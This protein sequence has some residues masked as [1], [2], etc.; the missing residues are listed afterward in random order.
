MRNSGVNNI[1]KIIGLIKK[2]I[3]IPVTKGFKKIAID[4]LVYCEGANSQTSF[5]FSDKAT[6]IVINRSLKELT[7][8]LEAKGFVRIHK[9]YFINLDMFVSFTNGKDGTVY[10]SGNKSLTVSRTYKK[11]FI[12]IIDKL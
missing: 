3:V 10:L 6:P 8:K 11:K 1:S 2:T 4:T 12:R 7:P 5:Y 9:R